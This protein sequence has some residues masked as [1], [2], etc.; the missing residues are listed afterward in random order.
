MGERLF[1]IETEY[2][3]TALDAQ[4][5]RLQQNGVLGG[6][7][8]NA[9]RLFP[10]LPD[11]VSHGVFLGNASRLYVDAGGHP[12]LSTPE[13]DNPWDV[14]RYVRAG[15]ATLLQVADGIGTRRPARTTAVFRGNV[16]YSGSG[17]TWGSHESYL[18]HVPPA[19]VAKPLIPH[20][21]SRLVYAGAGGFKNLSPGIEFTLSPRTA[22]LARVVSSD[23]T[24]NRGIFHEKDEDLCGGR[25]HR[26]H[27][28]CGES[29]CSELALWL[30]VGVTALVVALCE[31]GLAHGEAVEL[32]SPLEAMQ[33]FAG[34]PT[35]T[36][37]AESVTGVRLT[38]IAIQRHYLARVEAH[39]GDAFMP[40]W[41]GEVC[42]RWRAVLDGLEQGWE[43]AATT[44]DWAI[45]LALFRDRVRRRGLT[46]ESLGP[47]TDV[48]RRLSLAWARARQ[49][50]RPMTAEIVL[51]RDGPIA[52]EVRAMTV[53]LERT[54]L[55][56]SGL[57]PF[58]EARAEL[59]EIDT[60]FGQVGEEGIFA[61]L[62][63][64]GVLTHHVEGVEGIRQAMDCPPRVPRA[65]VR[66][67]LVRELTGQGHRYC[68][69]WNGVW[70][71]EGR[72]CVDLRDP[73]A[74]TPEWKKWRA[75]GPLLPGEFWEEP[76]ELWEEPVQLPRPVWQW[77]RPV[78]SDRPAPLDPADPLDLN[79][80]A[81]M[82]RRGGQL[83]EAERLLRL[84]IEIEDGVV[85]PE[86]PKRP[87]RRNNLAVVL[88]RAGKLDEAQQMNAA[89]WELKGIGLHDLTSG[90]ILLVRIALRLL[91]GDRDVGLYLGQ[92][93]T[94]MSRDDLDYFGNV[95]PIWN[96]P[97]V[98]T[99]FRQRIPGEAAL[100]L[101]IVRIL[102]ERSQLPALDAFDAWRSAQPVPLDVPWPS[103]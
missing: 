82:C 35:C 63:A 81:L 92:L 5:A 56:W 33:R 46:W 43:T 4:G 69:A 9:R 44:L 21:V 93:R 57:R 13:C 83:T 51:A 8:R 18:L 14:V 75:D 91:A 37:T 2:A 99:M 39:V 72:R 70:D 54:G 29:L 76:V 52:A 22:H 40:P 87:H 64:A 100:L 89:A 11:E 3:L 71:T 97:D 15:D 16:D 28:I 41:A 42:R 7:M 34:D 27:L 66:G 47:W 96:I 58:L 95:A 26:L 50:D 60:R 88:M 94:L 103:V 65:Q 90:R 20:L 45:K 32:R 78:R 77:R 48:A 101:G 98:L 67:Q 55:T 24:S 19:S 53:T 68:C 73:F 49:G 85:A 1:G 25:H 74:A 31:A 36:A 84:A 30:R 12:E 80:A 62:D 6:L 59:F 61:A 38:A 102:N 23:S 86:S 17:S 79:E 10:H